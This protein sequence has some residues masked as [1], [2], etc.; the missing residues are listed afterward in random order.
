MRLLFILPAPMRV[1]EPETWAREEG[2]FW[3][4]RP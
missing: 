3:E 4:G 2:A 1:I